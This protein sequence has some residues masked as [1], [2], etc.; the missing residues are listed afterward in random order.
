MNMDSKR[1][2][3]LLEKISETRILV[4]GDYFLDQYWITDPELEETSLETGLPAN[5]VVEVRLSAGAAGTVANNLSALG[6]KEVIALGII[7]D[8]GNGVIYCFWISY[9]FC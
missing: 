7:G 1:L 4:F 6:V 2:E 3:R 5:Q 9:I 8:D